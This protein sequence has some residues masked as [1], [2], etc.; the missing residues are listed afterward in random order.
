MILVGTISSLCV[1]IVLV[2]L[3]ETIHPLVQYGAA[4]G[5]TKATLAGCV[6][7]LATLAL[8]SRLGPAS[9][10]ELPGFLIVAASHYDLCSRGNCK[11]RL[12]DLLRNTMNVTMRAIR[13]LDELINGKNKDA[14]RD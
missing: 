13:W 8:I 1:A 5:L 4:S 7:G 6:W 2:T 11:V 9:I 10:V 14:E 3:F 12:T